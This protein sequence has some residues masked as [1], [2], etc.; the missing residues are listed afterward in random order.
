MT[1]Y[2]QKLILKNTNSKKSKIKILTFDCHQ[3]FAL[4]AKPQSQLCCLHR[5]FCGRQ[6]RE[7]LKK[8]AFSIFR[9]YFL[10]SIMKSIYFVMFTYFRL[11]FLE[12]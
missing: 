11:T 8:I 6:M 4:A 3:P 9:R 7:R 10:Q 12:Y 2:K 1:Q 5:S